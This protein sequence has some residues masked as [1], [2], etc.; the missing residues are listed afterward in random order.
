RFDRD[1]GTGEL[2]YEGCISSDSEVG[3]CAPIP[4]ATAFGVGTGLDGLFSVAVS[5]DG[6]R[7]YA[8][9]FD[10]DAVA[11]FDRDVLTGALTYEDCS[12]SNADVGACTPI[13]GATSGGTNTGLDALRAVAVSAGGESIYA[14]S[15]DGDAV[16]R[17]DRD[18]AE[19]AP[20][21]FS[22]VKLTRN[23]RR[24]TARLTVR[25]PASGRLILA[26]PGVRRASRATTG[27]GPV[28]LPVVARG[29]AA[30]QLRRRG[31]VRVSARVTYTPDGG[32]P[33]TKAK[34]IKLVRRR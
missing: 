8:A 25:V 2:A 27:P 7:V 17:F 14:A 32:A 20:N 26:G 24:G 9:S 4:G 29:R 21:Q 34:R 6:E 18:P 28:A 3:G 11:R 10:G 23:R 31:T 5:A 15:F 30:K 19:P 1:P 16:A 22:F 13:P 12:S 33:R